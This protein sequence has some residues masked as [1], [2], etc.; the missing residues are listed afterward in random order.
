MK[1]L[2]RI[3]SQRLAVVL[4]AIPVIGLFALLASLHHKGAVAIPSSRQFQSVLKHVE[5]SDAVAAEFG[6][7]ILIERCQRWRWVTTGLREEG[8]FSFSVRGVRQE[9][10]VIAYWRCQDRDSPTEVYKIVRSIRGSHPKVLWSRGTSTSS[11]SSEFRHLPSRP[12]QALQPTAT[13]VMHPA[14]AGC[15]PAAAVADL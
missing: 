5:S 7:I 13:A 12:N 9:G 15:P 8:S 6:S 3:A 2:S 4:L 10:E 11:R 14:D 1:T